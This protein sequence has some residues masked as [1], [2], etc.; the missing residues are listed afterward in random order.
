[1]EI[2]LSNLSDIDK[3]NEIYIHARN[4]MKE[5]NNPIQWGDV[6]PS[7]D[8]IIGK[9]KE[10]KHYSIFYNDELVGCFSFIIGK[11]PTYNYIE[12]SWLNNEEYGT[13]HSLA[14]SGKIKGIFHVIKEFCLTKVNNIRIDTHE[15]NIVM[16][17]IL[18]KEGFKYCGVIYL[19]NGDPRL[20]YQFIHK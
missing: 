16:Q 5:T 19:L 17:N 4:F 11:D 13:I 12:G 9:I 18:S 10:G 15:D 6:E 14:S 1:M 2:K 8:K 7:K 20:A 3:I